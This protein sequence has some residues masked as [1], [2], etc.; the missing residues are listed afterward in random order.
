ME[1]YMSDQRTR[2]GLP[3]QALSLALCGM[4]STVPLSANGNHNAQTTTPIKHIVVIF[5]ENRS[6]DQYVATY[7][8]AANLPGETPFF[9]AAR[10]ADGK[11]PGHGGPVD[12]EPEFLST[13]ASEP[14]RS[15]RLQRFARLHR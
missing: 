5:Q 1:N 4:L 9:R 12:S 14:G 8:N 15:D 3:R 2:T 6:F 7:P 10:Y 13:T 11:W